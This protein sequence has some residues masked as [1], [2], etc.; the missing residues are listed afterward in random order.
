[1][2]QTREPKIGHFYTYDHSDFTNISLFFK[3]E[4]DF[5]YFIEIDN[6][7][8]PTKL[9][10]NVVNED[11][12]NKRFTEQEYLK[13]YYLFV[14]FFDGY[15]NLKNN[16]IYYSVVS[17]KYILTNED[18]KAI[19]NA[20]SIFRVTN[21]IDDDYGNV[22]DNYQNYLQSPQWKQIRA[23]KLSN[24]GK[25]QLCGSKSNLEVHHNSYE[26]I[27]DEK[28]HLDDLVVLCRDCHAMFH[29]KR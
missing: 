11:D 7:G 26:H 16:N 21:H 13:D 23:I 20:V 28:N 4:R 15:E 6:G 3:K 29:Q 8:D 12:F 10:V 24:I 19:D 27:G 2:Q 5:L 22:K 25:C 9:W 1:M 14:W 18:Y 17:P